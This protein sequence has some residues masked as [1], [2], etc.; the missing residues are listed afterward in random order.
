MWKNIV[1]CFKAMVVLL[2]LIT[3]II[4]LPFFLLGIIGLLLGYIILVIIRAM[5]IDR[6]KDKANAKAK[7]SASY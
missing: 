3:G 4:A 7:A 2:L 5:R 1:D 6:E